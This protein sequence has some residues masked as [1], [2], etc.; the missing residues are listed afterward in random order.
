MA[1]FHDHSGGTEMRTVNGRPFS[2]GDDIHTFPQPAFF[3]S[4]RRRAGNA[5]PVIPA[6]A[7]IQVFRRLIRIALDP[8]LRRGDG[9]GVAVAA[10]ALL[11]LLLP[12]LLALPAA[13]QDGA[14]VLYDRPVLVVDPGRHTAPIRR[15]SVD[16]AGRYIVTGSHDK[17]VRVWD[18]ATGTLQ[19]T[20]R[21]PAGPGHVGKIYAVA[22]S[23]DGKTVAAGGLTG[24]DGEPEQI[25]L[26]DRESG[27]LTGRV[28]GL[29]NV[30]NHLTFSPDGRRLA[31]TFGV[32]G[33]RLYARD[34]KG[35][36]REAGR[37]ENYA[38][39]SYGAAF[40]AD[41][42]LATAGYDGQVRLYD[43]RLRR[44]AARQTTAGRRP[45]GVVFSP[46]GA[47]LAVGF[48]DSAG[49]E[50]LSGKNLAPL[51]SPDLSTID[52]GDL[53]KVAWSAD[54]ATLY[55]AGTFNRVGRPL[56][57]AWDRGGRG[58]PRFLPG[59][60]NTIMSLAALPDGGVLAAAQDPRLT[61]LDGQGRAVWNV[62]PPLA[63]YRVQQSTLAV[64]PDGGVVDFGYRPRGVDPARFNARDL[65]VSPSP[66]ADGAARPPRQSGL[67]VENWINNTRPT[68]DGKPLPLAPYETARAL[69]IT[70]D[71]DRFVLGADWLLRAFTADGALL[72]ERP[73]PG[74]VW[75]VNIADAAG[76]VIAAYA[77]GTIRWHRLE[78]GVE[79]LAFMP[80]ADQKNWVAWT[81]EGFFYATPAAR[82]LL[83]WHVNDPQRPWDVAPT[84]VAVDDIQGMFRP[85]IVAAALQPGER[86]GY[87]QETA[88]LR[89]KLRG[90]S[91]FTPGPKLHV[92]AVGIDDYGGAAQSLKLNYAA[93][94][95]RAVADAFAGDGYGLYGEV[96][97]LVLPDEKAT[98]RGVIKAL[99][100]LRAN[101]AGGQGR[102]VA[103]V[104][105]SAHGQMVDDEYHLLTYGVDLQDPADLRRR[106]VPG[107]ELRGHLR[108]LAKL[109][110]VAVILDTCHAGAVA[111]NGGPADTGK[112]AEWL[113]GDEKAK[114]AVLAAS[115]A[116]GAAMES[117]KLGHGYLT[118]AVLDALKYADSAPTGNGDGFISVQEFTGYVKA[119]VKKLG[120]TQNVWA[121]ASFDGELFT[122]RKQ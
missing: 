22:L 109:G 57:V 78:D 63:D 95:A 108:E 97:P 56:V 34:G 94:D 79:V 38:G 119:Q 68:L 53:S 60:D 71:A 26:F 84:G 21:L 85:D 117:K 5:S 54:G 92:L 8:G 66:A 49:I 18:A 27:R 114:I 50:I 61:R 98:D 69:A 55:A 89:E 120:G 43:A 25:Y 70:A 115:S 32:G 12:L 20:I 24:D 73:A 93:A 96:K 67:K 113:G 112:L 29:P 28:G 33:L 19:R 83:R 65:T 11:A 100:T 2:P 15:M 39:Q 118:A 17:T 111:G 81:P 74:A 107:R 90:R 51:P 106:T 9:G 102:D 10:A 82:K 36:W 77:D 59:A 44:I 3:P 99:M 101:M 23:P 46:D 116:D 122:A 88:A 52:N 64:S 1:G 35:E 80:L 75:A 45:F 4:Y 87:L 31:A 105:I 76:L 30:V 47:R 121:A 72:W 16:K 86:A 62:A 14:G 40:A 104:H 103:V 42:R 6:K 13:A 41:G 110:K 58:A 91:G 37:D 48:D 7:G